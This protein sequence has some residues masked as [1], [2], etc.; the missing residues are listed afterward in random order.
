MSFY[1]IWRFLYLLNTSDIKTTLPKLGQHSV[2][3]LLI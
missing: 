3:G 1:S 2:L